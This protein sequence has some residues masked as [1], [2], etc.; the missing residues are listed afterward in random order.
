MKRQTNKL[1]NPRSIFPLITILGM[2]LLILC[3]SFYNKEWYF[4]WSGIR[5]QIK[6]SIEV[7]KYYGIDAKYVG[8]A[9]RKS[10][11]YDRQRWLM[12]NATRQEL[13]KL[14]TYPDETIKAIAY[15]GLLRDPS[16]TRNDKFSIVLKVFKN[17]PEYIYYTRGCVAERMELSQYLMEN[18]LLENFI[19]DPD[20]RKFHKGF[21]FTAAQE[22][23]LLNKYY[24]LA[25]KDVN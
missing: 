1:K 24:T 16:I 2:T 25:D 5:P 21:N 17:H 8:Y 7:A 19:F 12:K 10:N 15:K 6:D 22:Q 9:N 20:N 3:S 13:E 18:V 11:Q 23:H 4:D 14:T